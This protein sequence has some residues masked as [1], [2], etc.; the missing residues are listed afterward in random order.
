[1][2]LFRLHGAHLGEHFLDQEG[3]RLRLAAVEAVVRAKQN[4]GHGEQLLLHR[5]VA[6]GVRLVAATDAVV[7]LHPLVLRLGEGVG[8]EQVLRRSEAERLRKLAE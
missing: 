7:H 8:T 4:L 3:G 6:R 5:L 2:K 1:M